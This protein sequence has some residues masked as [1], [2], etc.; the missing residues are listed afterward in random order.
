MV[1]IEHVLWLFGLR[2]REYACQDSAVQRDIRVPYDRSPLGHLSLDV[3]G[4]L[5]RGRAHRRH[6]EFNHSLSD[7]WI[8]KTRSGVDINF[9]DDRWCRLGRYKQT[10]P[11]GDI[12]AR[13][14]S[15]G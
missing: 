2:S 9:V 7:I 11:R 4:K 15:F 13:H 6:S 8:F 14:A 1:E 3:A 12:E 5:L 10:R